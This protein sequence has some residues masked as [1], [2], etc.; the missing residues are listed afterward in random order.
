MINEMALLQHKL[1][2]CSSG[3]E[4]KI[5]IF[6]VQIYTA[7]QEAPAVL[8]TPMAA[9]STPSVSILAQ[10][11]V[12]INPKMT[13]LQCTFLG[14]CGIFI[15]ILEAVR[16]A[17]YQYYERHPYPFNLYYGLWC[18]GLIILNSAVGCLCARNKTRAMV[19]HLLCLGLLY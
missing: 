18:G 19:G 14:L 2:H 1:W 4:T 3:N 15:F 11:L 5:K 10:V 13:W 12:N 6:F 9:P 16:C 8:P 17:A 7:G